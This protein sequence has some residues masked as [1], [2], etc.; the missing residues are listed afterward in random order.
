MFWLPSSG[1]ASGWASTWK[2]SGRGK[3]KGAIQKLN[4]RGVTPD[5]V[6]LCNELESRQQLD[7]IGGAA[8]LTGLINAVPSAL[9]VEAYA[10][11]VRD[12]A[13]RRRLI[14]AASEVAQL[15]YD[16]SRD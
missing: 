9:R 6:T 14:H 8:Y 12:T 5:F 4:R 7:A 16:E 13:I 1:N 2:A 15:A 11:I 10:H 3:K